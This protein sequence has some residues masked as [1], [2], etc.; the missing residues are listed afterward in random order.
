MPASLGCGEDETFVSEIAKAIDQCIHLGL[1]PSL[2]QDGFKKTGRTF[3]RQ[4]ELCTQLV[5]VQAS[6]SNI[7][8][9][10][11]FTLNLGIYFPT[12]EKLVK[13]TE[14]GQPPKE[15]DCTLRQRIGQLMP[16]H[17]GDKWWSIDNH[18]D[19]K[20]ISGEISAAWVS[21]GRP[22]IE[23]YS[24]LGEAATLEWPQLEHRVAMLILLNQRE[25][26]DRV[27]RA[28]LAKT[29]RNPHYR[30]GVIRWAK[31]QGLSVEA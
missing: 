30:T 17:G 15:Y 29:T 11:K 20:T 22:W 31:S 28:G 5:N 4:I 14:L 6:Q 10:G 27:L 8:N 12:V 24:Q 23:R 3:M 21:F 19:L 25:E 16:E 7:G 26:A 2:K 13:G 9:T 1:A 18:S